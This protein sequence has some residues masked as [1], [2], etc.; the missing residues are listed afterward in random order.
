MI[1]GRPFRDRHPR[2]GGGLAS[3]LVLAPRVAGCPRSVPPNVTPPGEPAAVS[4]PSPAASATSQ[5]E[6]R[7]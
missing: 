6:T 7:K 5:T 2:R 1:A 3:V 4:E